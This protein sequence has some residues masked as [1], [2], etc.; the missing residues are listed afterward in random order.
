MATAEIALSVPLWTSTSVE[1]WATVWV[2]TLATKSAYCIVS[3]LV[4]G[5]VP[6]VVVVVAAAQL[7]VVGQARVLVTADES[8]VHGL[9][10]CALTLQTW[11]GHQLPL[12]DEEV[13]SV[14]ASLANLFELLAHKLAL[15]VTD[16]L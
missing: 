1:A 9:E 14:L 8:I 12:L 11:K 7:V 6:F 5:V 2:S 13:T 3:L 10:A 16:A 15:R 4:R